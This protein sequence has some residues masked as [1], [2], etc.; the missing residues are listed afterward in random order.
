[1]RTG[2]FGVQ[3]WDQAEAHSISCLRECAAEGVSQ[4]E[5]PAPAGAWNDEK[6]NR[7]LSVVYILEVLRKLGS[8]SKYWT[9]KVVLCFAENGVAGV[10][11]DNHVEEAK[12]NYKL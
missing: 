4:D 8:D 7:C 2:E 3:S 12:R 1:M 9:W 5:S 11:A 6:G 10:V